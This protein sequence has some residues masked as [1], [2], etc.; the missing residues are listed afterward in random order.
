MDEKEIIQT[1][2]EETAKNSVGK[3]IDGI[4]SFFGK[5]CLPAAEEYGLYLRDKVHIY[6]LINLNKIVNKTKVLIKDKE[7]VSNISPKGLIEFIDRSSW[8]EDDVIQ[9]MWAG[10]LAGEITNSSQ[11]DS[12]FLYYNLLNEINPYQSRLIKLI[13]KDD[14]ICTSLQPLKLENLYNELNLQEQIS[15]P[16][17]KILEIAP[18]PLDYIVQGHKHQD[19]INNEDDHFLAL[20]YLLPNI[21]HLRRLEIIKSYVISHKE[22]TITFDPTLTGLDFYMNCTGLKVYPLEAYLVT[23]KYWLERK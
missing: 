13:F 17:R 1:V 22:R 4:G 15:I 14:R 18:K 12:N 6:R 3:I 9:N 23:R 10:L 8:N 16:I 20:G 7:I 5:I 19:I 2:V 21:T 11:T